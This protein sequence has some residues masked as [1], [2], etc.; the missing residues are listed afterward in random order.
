[1]KSLPPTL[2][3]TYEELL[4]RIDG[5]EDRT[6]AR[7]ILEL[8]SFSFT[9]MNLNEV[10]EYLQIT[11]GM[12]K[13]D[14][15]RCLANPKDILGICGS[16][17]NLHGTSGILSLAHHSVKTYLTSDIKGSASYFKLVETEAHR[18]IATRC[19]TYLSFDQFASG[20][21]PLHLLEYRYS[22]FPLLH[23]AAQ[24]WASHTKALDNLG[25][26]LWDILKSFLFSADQGR[27]NFVAWVQL[28]IPNSKYVEG[29]PPLYYAASFGV[30]TI[31][32]YL[33]DA[34]ADVECHGGRCGATPIN[35]ASFRGHVEVVKLLLDHGADPL[36]TDETP[37]WNAV[38]WAR[39]NGHWKILELFPGTSFNEGA[40][41]SNERIARFEHISSEQH[42]ESD[43]LMLG[44]LKVVKVELTPQWTKNHSS[45]RLWWQIVSLSGRSSRLPA[46]VAIHKAAEAILD[47]K[48]HQKVIGTSEPEGSFSNGVASIVQ[49]AD[50]LNEERYCVLIGTP[51]FLAAM[52]V[53]WSSDLLDSPLELET[54]L[55][56]PSSSLMTTYSHVAI[57]RIYAGVISLHAVSPTST[58]SYSTHLVTAPIPLPSAPIELE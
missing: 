31:V 10:C 21:C 58:L 4:L 48:G 6:L 29:T 38:Q 42:Q 50:A 13:L 55:S 19:L 26:S 2:D 27:G 49:T 54:D 12:S 22:E 28:L 18:K 34:G 43:P 45:T 56:T 24:R 44:S 25:D 35:I 30:T 17:L 36:A 8:L 5:D 47:P 1:M 9:P 11:P 57:D 40:T 7:E 20:P 33:L 52:G 16:L 15:S 39:Y 51:E 23:Y 37:G 46:I 3:K 32:K 41:E 14:D 53:I